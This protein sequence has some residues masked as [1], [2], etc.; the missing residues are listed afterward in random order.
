M[1]IVSIVSIVVQWNYPNYATYRNRLLLIGRGV[2]NYANYANY[3]NYGLGY[4]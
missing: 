1:A 2:S 4:S 3:A